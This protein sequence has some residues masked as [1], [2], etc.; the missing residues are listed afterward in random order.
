M[1]GNDSIIAVPVSE[2]NGM[3]I[4]KTGVGTDMNR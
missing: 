1:A 2:K 3:I 4:T